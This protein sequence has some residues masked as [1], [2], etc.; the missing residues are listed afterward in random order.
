MNDMYTKFNSQVVEGIMTGSMEG[1]INWI[2]GEVIG[3]QKRIEYHKNTIR[4]TEE[5]DVRAELTDRLKSY[6]RRLKNFKLSETNQN[7]ITTMNMV[8]TNLNAPDAFFARYSRAYSDAMKVEYSL[9]IRFWI[10]LSGRKKVKWSVENVKPS[11]VSKRT[12]RGPYYTYECKAF[13]KIPSILL[14]LP[15]LITE[16][17]LLTDPEKMTPYI[18]DLKNQ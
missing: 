18:F 3:L 2:S 7:Y 13:D 16:E 15:S 5:N 17:K 14:T 10:N 11:G 8:Y 4:I 12:F 6:E 9:D 1:K